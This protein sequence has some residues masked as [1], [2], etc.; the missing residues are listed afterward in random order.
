MMI[1][2]LRRRWKYE[3]DPELWALRDS[4]FMLLMWMCWVWSKR[5]QCLGFKQDWFVSAG[6]SA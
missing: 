5:W 2:S 6:L 1:P 4:D 3:S